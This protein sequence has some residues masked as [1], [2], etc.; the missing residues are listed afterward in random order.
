MEILLGTASGIL[1][2]VFVGLITPVLL[3]KGHHHQVYDFIRYGFLRSIARTGVRCIIWTLKLLRL[4]VV[5]FLSAAMVTIGFLAAASLSNYLDGSNQFSMRTTV[6]V[7]CLVT[8]GNLFTI[9]LIRNAFRKL[10]SWRSKK[11]QSS[12]DI[13]LVEDK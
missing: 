12:A 4:S 13:G 6:T 11:G 9:Y 5:L 8:I 3:E 1:I 7:L 2:G 10:R